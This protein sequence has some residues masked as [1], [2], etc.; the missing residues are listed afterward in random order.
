MEGHAWRSTEAIKEVAY[1]PT[2]FRLARRAPSMDYYTKSRFCEA[3]MRQ[4]SG[5]REKVYYRL[6][7]LKSGQASEY[8]F[9]YCFAAHAG[10]GAKPCA[11]QRYP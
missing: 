8:Q 11:D 10:S 2:P 9:D 7:G 3:Q 4:M 5:G 6:D 1:V